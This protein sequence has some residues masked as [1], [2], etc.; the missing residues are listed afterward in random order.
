MLFRSIGDRVVSTFFPDWQQGDAQLATFARTPGDDLD[1]YGVEM[2]VRPANWF[3]H[4]PRDWSLAE[5]A[6]LPTA[7]L[8]AWRALVVEGQ[9]RAGQDV[10]V[11]GTGG[12][13]VFALQLAKQMGARVIVTSSSDEKLERARGLGADFF[14]NFRRHENWSA[15]V[16]ELTK[17]RGV[18]LVVETSGPGT[19]PQS[20]QATRIGGA[21]YSSA[22]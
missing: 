19:L 6:T 2:V 21:S 11:L 5:A 1:G 20:I 18:D 12:V 15:T 7:S 3:T 10:L 14:V 22:S 13:S 8:T 9:L 16:L 4:V 17:G